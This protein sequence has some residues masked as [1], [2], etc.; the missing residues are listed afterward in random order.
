MRAT[1]FTGSGFVFTRSVFV[2][3]GSAFVFTG[4]PYSPSLCASA[5]SNSFVGVLTLI[6][7][8][9]QTKKQ[10]IMPLQLE[11]HMII[12][13]QIRDEIL[14]SFLLS[15][16]KGFSA[17][18][19]SGSPVFQLRCSLVLELRF[20]VSFFFNYAKFAH[21]KNEHGFDLLLRPIINV[22]KNLH[23]VYW[24]GLS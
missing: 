18:S 20:S 15:S 3:T 19:N 22:K 23:W 4:S 5:R 11:Q 10:R 9:M 17:V 1:V 21:K 7:S 24:V 13:R 12:E 8:T 6:G 14:S 16:P 2:F